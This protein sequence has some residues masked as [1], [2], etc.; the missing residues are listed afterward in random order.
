MFVNLIVTNAIILMRMPKFFQDQLSNW[1][2]FK[3]VL[4]KPNICKTCLLQ[5]TRI[6]C[7]CKLRVLM[8][9]YK[10]QWNS[11]Q[12]VYVTDVKTFQSHT[13][14]VWLWNVYWIILSLLID[15]ELGLVMPAT[16]VFEY[17]WPQD[18]SGEWFF[19]QEQ[20]SE[21]LGVTSFKRKY[22]GERL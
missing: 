13:T 8:D 16:N 11:T 19:V 6:Y 17:Q 14:D 22:P 3:L 15:S 2:S 5:Q 10:F 12:S 18:G 20:I 4:M 7:L 21:Y 1:I 9:S